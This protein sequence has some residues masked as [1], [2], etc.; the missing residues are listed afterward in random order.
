MS[1]WP[2]RRSLLASLGGTA[3]VLAAPFPQT[4]AGEARAA[5]G[6]KRFVV[7]Y[8]GNGTIR[9]AWVPVGSS[10]SFIAEPRASL[11]SA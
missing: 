9:D 1:F 4:R 3:A 5:T 6:A 10:T 2:T 7:V 8:S 11:K